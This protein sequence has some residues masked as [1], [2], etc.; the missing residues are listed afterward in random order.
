VKV[1]NQD[2]EE[3]KGTMIKKTPCK[4]KFNPEKEVNLFVDKG[5]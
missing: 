5:G 1:V 4:V 3:T 2:R